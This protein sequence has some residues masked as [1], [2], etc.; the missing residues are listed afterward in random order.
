MI[1]YMEDRKWNVEMKQSEASAS[2][3]DAKGMVQAF[4][5]MTDTNKTAE[6]LR[7]I[8]DRV[9]QFK[10]SQ[11]SQHQGQQV[12]FG[13][14]DNDDKMVTLVDHLCAEYEIDTGNRNLMIDGIH[15][16]YYIAEDGH[17]G[18]R[19]ASLDKSEAR[20][21][22]HKVIFKKS[23]GTGK[24]NI[25]FVTDSYSMGF[26]PDKV[27]TPHQNTE[28]ESSWFGFSSS[29]STSNWIEI[30]FVEHTVTEQ[31]TRDLNDYM[32]WQLSKRF[33]TYYASFIEDTTESMQLF[34][35]QVQLYEKE[36]KQ[37]TKRLDKLH[38][39]LAHCNAVAMLLKILQTPGVNVTDLV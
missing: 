18:A 24:T 23:A 11:M 27:V 28:C 10:I 34:E 37:I 36:L 16:I 32:N 29:C 9:G 6:E 35:H 5:F 19:G 25:V 13:Y 17:A 31:D 21:Q 1:D 20:V 30:T 22:T 33:A 12:Y 39:Q 4:R 8:E 15:S 38:E 14:P 2:Y 3:I 26:P 7:A